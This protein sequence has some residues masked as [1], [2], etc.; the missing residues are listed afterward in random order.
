MSM[1]NVHFIQLE[2]VQIEQTNPPLLF[3]KQ[4]QY[5]IHMIQRGKQQRKKRY[6]ELQ[7]NTTASGT[8]KHFPITLAFF[9]HCEL[10]V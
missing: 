6:T 1:T 9:F 2:A 8:S 3:N 10:T 5:H 4:G 7:L